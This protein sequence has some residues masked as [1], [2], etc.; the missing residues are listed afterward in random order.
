MFTQGIYY[1]TICVYIKAEKVTAGAPHGGI[2][3]A[4]DIARQSVL[5]VQIWCRNRL[6]LLRNGEVASHLVHA[7]K[8]VGFDS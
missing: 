8:M 3:D 4:G 5:G 7:Q 1:D 2:Q 6:P